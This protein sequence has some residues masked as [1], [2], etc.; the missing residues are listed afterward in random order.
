VLPTAPVSSEK[1]PPVPAVVAAK[2]EPSQGLVPTEKLTVRPKLVSAPPVVIPEAAKAA[3]A[4]GTQV[5]RCVVS[6]KGT[7]EK[8]RVVK[9]VPLLDEAVLEALKARV[10]EPARVGAEAV[11]T[12]IS[13]VVHLS[14][15]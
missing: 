1:A 14:S 12:E 13:V 4:G 9:S 7:L 8:C 6:V 5:S 10:Y 11:A 3:N 15:R 2:V